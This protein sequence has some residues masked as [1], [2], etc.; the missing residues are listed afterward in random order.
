LQAKIK[1]YNRKGE[2]F[3]REVEMLMAMAYSNQK[4]T[5]SALDQ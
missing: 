1:W 2:F 4:V 3:F 5:Q